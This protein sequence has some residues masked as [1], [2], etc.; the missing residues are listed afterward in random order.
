MNGET[1]AVLQQGIAEVR[2]GNKREGA[3]LLAQVV[4]SEP[5]SE[6]AWF[7]L[8]AATDQPTEASACLSQVLRINPNNERAKQA[9]AM[10]GQSG[11][12]GSLSATPPPVRG[13]NTGELLGGG[14][15]G[16][17]RGL[18][19]GELLGGSNIASPYAGSAAT[20]APPPPPFA[21]TPTNSFGGTAYDTAPFSEEELSGSAPSR[22][23]DL[24]SS[25]IPSAAPAVPPPPFGQPSWA[26]NSS[27]T[28]TMADPYSS[29]PS[30]TPPPNF[31]GGSGGLR[32]G[33]LDP[34][35]AAQQAAQAQQ[36]T[37]QF[38]D[39]GAEI[40][41]GLLADTPVEEEAQPAAAKGKIKTPK[42][43]PT[44]IKLQQPPRPK[45]G[46]RR[47][48][49]WPLLIVLIIAVV[50]AGVVLYFVKGKSDN[51]TPATSPTAVAGVTT[52]STLTP[53]TGATQVSLADATKSQI[54]TQVNAPANPAVVNTYV[55]SDPP[56][57]ISSFYTTQFTSKGF[58]PVDNGT[59]NVTFY[60]SPAV[61]LKYQNPNTSEIGLVSIAPISANALNSLPDLN[62]K[63]QLNNTL[64]VLDDYAGTATTTLANGNNST[65]ATTPAIATTAA[66]AST[67]S[68]ATTTASASTSAA[69]TT[70]TVAPANTTTVAPATTAATTTAATTTA[71]TTT[72]APATTVAPTTAPATTTAATTTGPVFTVAPTLAAACSATSGPLQPQ[73]TPDGTVVIPPLVNGKPPVDVQQYVA[74]SKALM[75]HL[76][77]YEQRL[78]STVEIPFCKGQI[79]PEADLSKLFRTDVADLEM[80]QYAYNLKNQ[81]VPLG[82]YYLSEIAND[83]ANDIS[84]ADKALEDF[85]D[86]GKLENL[87]L[88][89]QYTEQ[90]ARDRARWNAAL[91]KGYPYK[92]GK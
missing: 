38:Y 71:A 18:N 79:P 67:T 10:L 61:Q 82:A 76:L 41:A 1:E 66:N 40:R 19:T 87:T 4:K 22:P 30:S 45:A 53:Y 70:T 14:N 26:D 72:A 33:Q 21:A 80:S 85:F 17:S 46:R 91:A 73:P 59:S 9:L 56:S 83:Y 68:A 15:F 35:L 69:A 58:Q 20:V 16:G 25:S 42:N 36:N 65:A 2:A 60:G 7:W 47:S 86:S 37:Q 13:L 34:A 27:Q 51:S 3:R 8:A 49:L 90:A 43:K 55:S 62:S 12:T 64:V 54:N 92:L 74:N 32:F 78:F 57:T 88:V 31:G 75:A 84:N 63:A 50:I 24:F 89:S 5:R 29:M 23:S 39:P 52:L 44:K 77:P 28:G 6:E 48:N 11:N 81:Y